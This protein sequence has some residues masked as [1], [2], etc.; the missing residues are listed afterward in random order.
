MAVE[1]EARELAQA[2]CEAG[3]A[4]GFSCYLEQQL[5]PLLECGLD[6]LIREFK[7]KDLPVFHSRLTPIQYLATWLNRNNPRHREKSEQRLHQYRQWRHRYFCGVDAEEVDL[8]A[9]HNAAS[10]LQKAA[11]HQI[12]R[13]SKRA[14][15]RAADADAPYD[16]ATHEIQAAH[17]GAGIRTRLSLTRP[18]EPS[19]I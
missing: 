4:A 6:A 10:K 13:H 11:R 9:H 17:G 3:E 19:C 12:A 18:S 7:Q 2:A 8:S 1:A 14:A 5:L 15:E 16:V